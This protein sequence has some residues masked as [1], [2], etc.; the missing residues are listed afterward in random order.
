MSEDKWF[1]SV[2]RTVECASSWVK[3]L[4]CLNPADDRTHPVTKVSRRP[5]FFAKLA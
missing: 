1:P 3:H 5:E 2:H 4:D